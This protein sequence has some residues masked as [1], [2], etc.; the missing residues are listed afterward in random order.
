MSKCHIANDDD[1]DDSNEVCITL[2]YS[3]NDNN[4]MCDNGEMK[5]K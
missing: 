2:P 5:R 4:S 3:I 1:D